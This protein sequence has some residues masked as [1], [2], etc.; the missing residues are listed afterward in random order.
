MTRCARTSQ[1]VLSVT[2]LAGIA[3]AEDAFLARWQEVEHRQREGVSLVLSVPKP[4]FYLGE[5]IRVEL[6]F[7]ATERE[8]FLAWAPWADESFI[9]YPATHTDDLQRPRRGFAYSGPGPSFLSEKPRSIPAD[10]NESVRFRQPGVY[11]IYVLS[12]RVRQA[13]DRARAETARQLHVGSTPV[14][15]VSNILTLEIKPAPEAWVKERIADAVDILD[16][17]VSTDSER[18]AARRILLFLNTREAALE[19][20]KRLGEDPIDQGLASSP[21]QKEMLAVMEQRLIA[22]DQPVTGDYLYTLA[23]IAVPE[24]PGGDLKRL[25]ETREQKRNEYATR[26]L[27]AVM[28]K[29]PGAR[30]VSMSTLL[31]TGARLGR[32]EPWVRGIAAWTTANFGTFPARVQYQLLAGSAWQALMGPAMIPVLREICEIGNPA[33]P[34]IVD[35]ALTRLTEISP[36]D[37]GS[38]IVADIGRPKSSFQ[39]YTFA[40]LPLDRLPEA[41]EPLAARLESDNSA[42]KLIARFATGAIVQRVEEAYSLRGERSRNCISPLVFYFLRYDPAFGESELRRILSTKPAYPMCWNVSFQAR[43]LAQYA[44][45]P[46]LE[47]LAIEYLSSGVAGIKNGFAELLGQYGSSAAKQPLWDTMVYFRSWWKGREEELKQ[48]INQEGRQFER[49]LLSALTNGRVWSLTKDDLDRLLTLCSSDE[50]TAAITGRLRSWRPV[51][52]PPARP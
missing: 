11:R 27:A 32:Q 51:A 21:Y 48:P 14:E 13:A 10:L 35:Q 7:A 49:T 24:K 2:L 23:A 26:L 3:S 40:M 20:A 33:Y 4:A 25:T 31:N 39:F 15:L 36:V 5:T 6:L 19:L 45:S 50:C 9:I 8:T 17:P 30:A 16:R 42:D 38:I 46:A 44:M 52:Q 12:H 37:A 47:R 34:N 41:D 43:D 22:T 29:Q 1:I 18:A 28:S